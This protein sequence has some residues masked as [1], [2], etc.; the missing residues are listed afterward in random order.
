M[1]DEKK[2]QTTSTDTSSKAKTSDKEQDS[3]E[4][5]TETEV[6]QASA[7]GGIKNTGPVMAGPSQ[8][9]LNPAFAPPKEDEDGK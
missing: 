2:A 1:A 3:K 9:D 8:D 7:T 4:P 6:K 5:T